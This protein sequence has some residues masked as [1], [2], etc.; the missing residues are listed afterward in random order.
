M[1]CSICLHYAYCAY[2]AY[3]LHLAV[4]GCVSAFGAKHPSSR[5]HTTPYTHVHAHPLTCARTPKLF[6][7]TR[8]EAQRYIRYHTLP[9][10]TQV[11]PPP[12]SSTLIHPPSPVVVMLP[13]PT[14]HHHTSPRSASHQQVTLSF[15]HPIPNAPIIGQDSNTPASWESFKK[16]PQL[17][18]S[19]N[20]LP[21]IIVK[22]RIPSFQIYLST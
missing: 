3:H 7:D 11:P 17:F 13:I 9:C 8:D 1:L 12:P 20:L 6:F 19:L 16:S 14:T 21:N 15:P 10:A 22:N 5:R 18:T 4:A 2:C